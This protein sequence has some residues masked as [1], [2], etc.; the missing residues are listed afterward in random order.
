MKT[1]FSLS[2]LAA[3]IERNQSAKKDFVATTNALRVIDG[4]PRGYQLE[5]KNGHTE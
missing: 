1:M 5:V 3:Q 4:G 2:E